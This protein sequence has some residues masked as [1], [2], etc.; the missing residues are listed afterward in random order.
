VVEEVTGRTRDQVFV[1]R[2][3]LAF[4]GREMQAP[5]ASGA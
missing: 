5:A 2:E 4:V 3:V 1:A